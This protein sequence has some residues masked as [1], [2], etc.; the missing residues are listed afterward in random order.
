MLQRVKGHPLP[1]SKDKEDRNV[2]TKVIEDDTTTIIDGSKSKDV[3]DET[4]TISDASTATTTIGDP[5][6]D[7][8]FRTAPDLFDGVGI[9]S[10]VDIDYLGQIFELGCLKGVLDYDEV[11]D[12]LPN[13]MSSSS[14]VD[15]VLAKFEEIGIDIIIH[16]FEG[17]APEDQKIFRRR[18]RHRC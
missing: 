7:T 13:T 17:P 5:S 11:N 12:L 16:E 18:R 6:E 8:S 9:E 3:S 1:M 14:D 4:T 10:N 2:E 15:Y